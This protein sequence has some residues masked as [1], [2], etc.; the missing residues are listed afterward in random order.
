MVIYTGMSKAPVKSPKTTSAP[1]LASSEQDIAGFLQKTAAMAN[2]VPKTGRRGRLVFVLD[3]TLSREATWDQAQGIQSDMFAETAR[4]GGLDVQ[5]VYFRGYNECRSSKWVSDPTELGRLM[6]NV[7]CRGGHTQIGKVLGHIKTETNKNQINAVVY[8]GDCMEE[9]IDRVC[10]TAGEIG[11][12]RV[13]VFMFQEGFDVSATTAFKEIARLT[14]GA[15]CR[16]SGNAADQL[17][18]LLRAVAVYATGGRAALENYA[19]KNSQGSVLLE[20]LK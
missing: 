4:I 10:K 5:L 13:P 14:G 18:Q 7:K 11:L 1:S 16:F 15:H 6:T 3:A 12:L 2:V 8:V 20:Q 9:N 17:R 19:A